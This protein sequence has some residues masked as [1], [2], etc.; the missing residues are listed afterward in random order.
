V[1]HCHKLVLKCVMPHK[2]V[3]QHRHLMSCSH[4]HC[5]RHAPQNIRSSTRCTMAWPGLA[6]GT[7]CSRHRSMLTCSATSSTASHAPTDTSR[8]YIH[9]RGS[10]HMQPHMHRCKRPLAD[11][12]HPLR[13]PPQ[14]DGHG[15]CQHDLHAA[16]QV[17]YASGRDHTNTKNSLLAVDT[18][19]TG[20]GGPLR[21]RHLLHCATFCPAAC[22]CPVT[23][24]THT[25]ETSRPAGL[26]SVPCCC[27]KGTREGH[28]LVDAAQPLPHPPRKA[29]RRALPTVHLLVGM[30]TPSSCSCLRRGMRGWATSAHSGPGNDGTHSPPGWLIMHVVQPSRGAM[31]ASRQRLA[32]TQGCCWVGVNQPCANP[33]GCR[34]CYQAARLQQPTHGCHAPCCVPPAIQLASHCRSC[35][36]GC[37][38]APCEWRVAAGGD[39]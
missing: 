8:T 9:I 19:A 26:H 14:Q 36:A 31:R 29:P 5:A 13:H 25:T 38:Y 20:G 6:T 23:T 27:A 30:Q 3:L 24:G 21:T 33:A 18:E 37:E 35:G 7:H 2:Q 10:C 1:V 15:G 11:M 16:A 12:P 4:H 22:Q 17:R 34:L 28:P 39:K 32:V